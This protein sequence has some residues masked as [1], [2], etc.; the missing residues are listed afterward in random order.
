MGAVK[1]LMDE[2]AARM[3]VQDPNDPR[4]QAEVERLLVEERTSDRAEELAQK[5]TGFSFDGLPSQEQIRIWMQAEQ[6]VRQELDEAAE[7]A[8]ETRADERR[9]IYMEA[10]ADER[11]EEGRR[12]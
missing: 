4:V 6:Q 1:H 12:A 11:R 9:E 8:W 2:V 3:E 7:R 10:R 5:Q